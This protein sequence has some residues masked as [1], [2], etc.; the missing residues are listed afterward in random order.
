MVTLEY[1]KCKVSIQ[2]FVENQIKFIV[3]D[4]IRFRNAISARHCVYE[5]TTNSKCK[6]YEKDDC[7]KY[8][9]SFLSEK[10]RN[11]MQLIISIRTSES[12]VIKVIF[13]DSKVISV[14]GIIN[15]VITCIICG[16]HHR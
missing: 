15:Y 13:W 9:F 11:I 14:M 10:Y 1:K 5:I 12:M 2:D 6:F 4:R 8:L 3:I 7:D 16:L